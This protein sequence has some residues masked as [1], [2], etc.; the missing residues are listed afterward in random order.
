MSFVDY[1]VL[2]V[3][4]FKLACFANIG[5]WH[6]ILDHLNFNSHLVDKSS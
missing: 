6:I 3:C 5:G 2:V 4:E 1:L